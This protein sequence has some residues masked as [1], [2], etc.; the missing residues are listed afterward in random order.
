[1]KKGTEDIK[2]KLRIEGKIYFSRRGVG[3]NW[4]TV[5]VHVRLRYFYVRQLPLSHEKLNQLNSIYVSV[6]DMLYG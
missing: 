2:E 6:D 5:V 1:M 4:T 3:D